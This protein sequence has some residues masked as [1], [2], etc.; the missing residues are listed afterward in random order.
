MK[1]SFPFPRGLPLF[2]SRGLNV[3]RKRRAR[4]TPTRKILTRRS[5]WWMSAGVATCWSSSFFFFSRDQSFLPRHRSHWLR[6]RRRD[7]RGGPPEPRFL[8]FRRKSVASSEDVNKQVMNEINNQDLKVLSILLVA[9]GIRVR[10]RSMLPFF[11]YQK[12]LD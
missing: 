4:S 2:Y 5:E 3:P 10:N 1:I 9:N 7:Y 12:Y 11:S 6:R 8:R